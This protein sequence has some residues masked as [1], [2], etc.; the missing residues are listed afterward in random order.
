MEVQKFPIDQNK[1]FNRCNN[2]SYRNQVNK[3][4]KGNGGFDAYQDFDVTEDVIGDNAGLTGVETFGPDQAF[5]R[6][7]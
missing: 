5:R 6:D 3:Q 1:P 7:C 2:R 4:K